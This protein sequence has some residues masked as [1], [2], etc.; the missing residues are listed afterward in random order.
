MTP[1]PPREASFEEDLTLAHSESCHCSVGDV[2]GNCQEVRRVVRAAHAREI[3]QK[4]VATWREAA[5]MLRSDGSEAMEWW[6]DKCE[7]RA[8]AAEKETK[9][10]VKF[11]TDRACP[12]HGMF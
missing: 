2:S 12:D 7:Q 9:H 3:Q 1:T 6:A 11:C 10:E 5:T 8:A 4:A